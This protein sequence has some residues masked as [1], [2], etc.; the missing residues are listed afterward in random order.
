[1]GHVPR[2]V[3]TLHD[4]GENAA[5][6]C[7][8]MRRSRRAPSS[9]CA[10]ALA[11]CVLALMPAGGQA[12]TAPPSKQILRVNVGVL[13]ASLDPGEA[14]YEA[15]LAVQNALFAPLYRSSGGTSGRITPF[16]AAAAPT[17]TNGGLRYTVRLRSARWSD[18]VAITARDVVLAFQRARRTSYFG[19]FFSQ[20]RSV[21]AVAPR[22]VRFDLDAPV[23]WFD[24]LLA[25]N[26][27]T[28]VPSHEIRSYGNKWTRQRTLVSSGPFVRVSARGRT[29]LVLGP[30][31]AWWGARTVKLREL[32][33]LAVSE[34][35]GTPLFRAERLD[36][37]LRDT[38]IHPT[39]LASWNGDPRL[40]TVAGSSAQFLYMNT[41]SSALANA[42]VRRGIA[43][44]LDRRAL[45]DAAGGIDRPLATVVPSGMRGAATVAPASGSLLAADGA[46]DLARARAELAAGGGAPAVSLD[47]YF[48]SDSGTAGDV[49]LLVRSQLEQV[50]VRVALRPTTSAELSK[51]GTGISPVRSDV[52]LVLQ[53]WMADYSD[54]ET[55]HQLFTC[56]NVDLGLNISG[57]CSAEYDAAFARAVAFA[58]FATRLAA[59]REL[60]QLLSGPSGAMPVA[61]LYEP[62]GEYLVQPW[63]RGYVHQPSGRVDFERVSIASH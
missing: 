37:T 33:L 59:H 20:V 5:L 23:P 53:G 26:V 32:Q 28:P 6:S 12:A 30:N 61:P 40:H 38:S 63:V 36:A 56:A 46:A 45:A 19:S 57:F 39:V 13:P 11:A 8:A 60:E 27:V 35:S 51:V 14:D 62:V 3:P 18:G 2:V 50:G 58:P 7:V 41:R 21:R 15:D 54:P 10:L 1:M 29:E 22:T 25:S 17:V 47:L 44:A 43:L 31:P 49:A 4:H 9:T 34:A 42:S 48:A 55:F 16:L 52:E 24:E